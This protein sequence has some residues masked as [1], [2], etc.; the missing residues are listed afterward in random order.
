M[1]YHRD[2]SNQKNLEVLKVDRERT[3]MQVP[4][5]NRDRKNKQINTSKKESQRSYINIRYNKH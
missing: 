5:I 3:T 4:I 1:C 2:T